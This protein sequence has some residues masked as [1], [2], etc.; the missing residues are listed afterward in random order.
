[1]NTN[2]FELKF[3][4]EYKGTT[5][6]ELKARRPKVRDLRSFIKDVERDSVNAME[7]VIGNLCEVDDKII[8]ELDL[9][10]FNPIK[11]W[12]EDFLKPMLGGSTES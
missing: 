4:F 11:Q 10:D 3:P 12:F 7:K 9:E 1:M 6:T 5:Y 8:A 2:T